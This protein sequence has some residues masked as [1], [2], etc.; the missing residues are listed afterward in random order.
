MRWFTLAEMSTQRFDFLPR[1]ASW[2]CGLVPLVALLLGALAAPTPAR[3]QRLS[4]PSPI[5]PAPTQAGSHCLGEPKNKLTLEHTIAGSINPLGIGNIVRLGWCTPLIR[6]PGLLFDFT[7]FDIGALFTNSPTDVNIGVQAFLS[8]LSILVL[9]AEATVFY[10][11]P[12]PLQGAGFITVNGPQE[13]TLARLSPDPT[14]T[15]RTTGMP[16][17]PATTAYGG[18]AMVGMTLQG[19]VPLGKKLDIAAAIGANIEYWSLSSSALAGLP[20]GGG[21]YSARRD[22]ILLGSSDWLVLSTAALLLNIKFHRNSSIKIGGVNDLAYVP[23]HGYLGNIAGGLIVWNVAN[24]RQLA[25]NFNLFARVGAFTHHQFRSGVT[26]ALGLSIVYE[27]SPKPGKLPPPEPYVGPAGDPTG[28][29][30][31]A[32]ADAAGANQGSAAT[33]PADPAA[34]QAL[35]PAT[36]MDPPPA[37][38]AAGR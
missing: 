17:T 33:A 30:P 25:K 31:A 3:A 5:R 7:N 35:P 24:L 38:P 13:F 16:E 27:L 32:G 22:V 12:I 29:N 19:Q 15:N 37:Q 6:K 4:V 18:R 1:R 2:S 20:P 34:P 28:A 23:S 26:I 21:F 8:P 11:W 14:G 36:V 10:I 9:R